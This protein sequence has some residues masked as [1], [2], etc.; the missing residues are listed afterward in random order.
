[1][2]ALRLEGLSLRYAGRDAPAVHDLDLDVADG[3]FVALVG[4]SGCGKS[5][6]LRLVAGFLRPDAGRIVVDGRV[7]SEPSQVVPPERR[8]MGMV[9]Q[10]F[11]VWPHL[12]V[13]ENVAF[14]L[15]VRRL[16]DRTIRERVAAM[17]ALVDLAGLERAYPSQLSGGQQQ[18]VALARALVVSPGTL[19]LD[20]PLSN[21]DASLRERMRGELKALQRRTGV[22]FVHVTHDQAEAI[23]VADRVAVMYEGRI[24]QVGPPREVYLR[25]ASQ[26]VAGLMGAINVVPGE[27]VAT[28]AGRAIV[29][30]LREPDLRVAVRVDRS[31]PGAAVH[32]LIRP[33][34]VTVAAADA[35]GADAV[36]V[37]TTF[38]GTLSDHVVTV[39]G[40]G[41]AAPL[42][43]RAL[44]LGRRAFET[45]E[46]VR[47]TIDAA[48]CVL[49][50]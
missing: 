26:R 6:T 27:V 4:P 30:L 25:P 50:E 28:E 45:G 40:E 15:R 23:A 38:L 24:E 39:V 33:E 8:N 49:V 22:T 43:L 2:G 31:P 35:A 11:A 13:F 36:I 18:R 19:L 41:P 10:G 12:S 17:L 14:G 34:D 47:V 37:Q 9:F 3:E 48:R 32:L 29:R 7:L 20:E 5:T 1:M 42:R 16:A 46:R 44:S 21:L